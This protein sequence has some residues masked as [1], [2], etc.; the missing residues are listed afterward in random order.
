MHM[1]YLDLFRGEEQRREEDTVNHK[2]VAVRDVIASMRNVER[3]ELRHLHF[4][5]GSDIGEKS[6]SCEFRK[7]FSSDMLE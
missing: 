5:P 6:K 7:T 2:E 1:C 4:C 3:K